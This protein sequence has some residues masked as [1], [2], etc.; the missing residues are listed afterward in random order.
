[1]P[2][3]LDQ[4]VALGLRLAQLLV[5]LA[6]RVCEQLASLV[7]GSVDDLGALALAVAAVALDLRVAAREVLL[8]LADV[9]LGPLELHCGGALRVLLD[10]VGELGCLANQVERVHAHCVPARLH[11]HRGAGGLEHAQLSLQLDDVT[12]K[13]FEGLA[14]AS[15][16]VALVDDR[17]ILRARKRRH[18]H[19]LLL[20][21]RNL[22]RHVLL[23][24]DRLSMAARSAVT[25]G[26]T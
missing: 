8:A 11:L 18:R 3:L 20:L 25:C 4:P 13:S 24:R 6:L 1:V 23:P 5:G 10:H 16:V 17:Q 14:H 7:P 12:A 21:G 19:G 9:L 2:R 15:L 26:P 22:L